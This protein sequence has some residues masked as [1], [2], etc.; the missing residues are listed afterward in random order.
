VEN[1]QQDKGDRSFTPAA[2]HRL[3]NQN[4]TLG[5]P[6][7]TTEP[8]RTCQS[9]PNTPQGLR[10]T[11]TKEPGVFLVAPWHRGFHEGVDWLSAVP[12]AP[13]REPGSISGEK[14]SVSST[15]VPEYLREDNGE[16]CLW[17]RAHWKIG[18]LACMKRCLDVFEDSRRLVDCCAWSGYVAQC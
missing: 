11:Q 5:G 8:S 1:R 10:L 4:R 6:A 18:H 17:I 2:Q 7:H 12:H 16:I 9:G 14:V 13:R 15:D 3:P